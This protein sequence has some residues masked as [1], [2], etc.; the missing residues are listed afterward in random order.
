MLTVDKI[1]DHELIIRYTN[2]YNIDADVKIDVDQIY[3][4]WELEKKLS[5]M[6][7]STNKDNRM[8]TFIYAYETLYKELPWLLKSGSNL[9][10]NLTESIYDK[11]WL[12]I[13]NNVKGLR[14][15]EV[16][17]GNGA[18]INCISE[19]GAICTGSEIAMARP[20]KKENGYVRW[21]NTDGINLTKFEKKASFDIVISDQLIEHLHPD[22]INDHFENSYALLAQGG[23]YIFYTPHFYSGPGDVSLIFKRPVAEAMHLKEYKYYELYNILK[24]SGFKNIKTID[25]KKINKAQFVKPSF[26]YFFILLERLLTILP[27]L[28][29]RKKVYHRLRKAFGINY[30]II[31]VASK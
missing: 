28:S 1:D 27:T 15:Y 17:S 3:K 8:E 24:Q 31:L 5:K 13:L 14:I 29:L 19:K 2:N 10:E 21:N 30:E 11:R 6:L 18:L 26:F 9:N 7:L 16:G 25:S 12:R 20:I 4:H 23:K 22:D